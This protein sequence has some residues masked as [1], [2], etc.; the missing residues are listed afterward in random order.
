LVCEFLD[1][2]GELLLPPPLGVLLPP[3]L[4]GPDLLVEV[5]L[6]TP[7]DCVLEDPILFD[8]LDGFYPAALDVLVEAGLFA[9]PPLIAPAGG[10]DG[11]P[12]GPRS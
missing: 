12:L 11:S 1:E 7:P 3:V 10:N 8:V 2:V 9:E 4:P 5:L 6:F